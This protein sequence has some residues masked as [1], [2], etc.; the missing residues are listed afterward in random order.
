MEGNNQKILTVS[1]IVLGLLAAVVLNVLLQTMGASFGVMAR[2][3]ANDFIQ[4]GLPVA[5]GIIVF[6]IL[7]F[8][9]KVKEWGNE[10]VVELKKVV[11]PSRKDTS[12]LTIVVCVMLLISGFVIGA[13]DFLSAYVLNLIVE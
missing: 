9:S 5:L 6:A 4:H 1:F 3:T 13:F 7:Q 8:N 11:W 12:A 2:L 10:V